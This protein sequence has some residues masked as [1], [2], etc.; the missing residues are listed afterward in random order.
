[1]AN[2]LNTNVV[3]LSVH[4]NEKSARSENISQS[5]VQNITDPEEWVF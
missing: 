4:E 2:K 5:E 1:M 3:Q